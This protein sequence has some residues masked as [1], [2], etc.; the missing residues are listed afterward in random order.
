[1]KQ[2]GS[3]S[4]ADNWFPYNFYC[5]RY[6]VLAESK[7]DNW[8]PYNFYCCRSAAQRAFV[9]LIIGFLIISTVVDLSL[10]RSRV[11]IIGFLI[12]ST[13]VDCHRLA[14]YFRGIIGFL[15]ISTVVDSV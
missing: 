3:S 6:E 1:M 4:Y 10:L 15:I 5:C 8:F 11:E 14:V 12:I 7:S 13:V 2:S 9:P